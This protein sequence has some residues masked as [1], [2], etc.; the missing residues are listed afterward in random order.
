MIK[1]KFRFS[2]FFSRSLTGL[3]I[4]IF[5]ATLSLTP[6]QKTQAHTADCIP[7]I[8][9][10]PHNNDYPPKV[11]NPSTGDFLITS[12]NPT[13][14]GIDGD[15]HQYYERDYK[16]FDWEWDTAGT[17]GSPTGIWKTFNPLYELVFPKLTSNGYPGSLFVPSVGGNIIQDIVNPTLSVID[18]NT[19]VDY[20]EKHYLKYHLKFTCTNHPKFEVLYNG[21]DGDELIGSSVEAKYEVNHTH[22]TPLFGPSAAGAPFR[23]S[24]TVR[25]SNGRDFTFQSNNYCIDRDKK[26]NY[27]GWKFNGMV[28]PNGN[29][30]SDGQIFSPSGTVVSNFN[31]EGTYSPYTLFG[32][33]CGYGGGGNTI[34]GVEAP[35]SSTPDPT[36]PGP[37]FTNPGTGGPGYPPPP[38]CFNGA[39]NYPL[40]S[41]SNDICLDGATNPPDCTKNATIDG[42]GGASQGTLSCSA[43]GQNGINLV[44]TANRTGATLLRGAFSSTDPNVSV[45]GANQSL[46]TWINSAVP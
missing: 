27:I 12:L 28:L 21:N 32:S 9:Q 20:S 35:P 3:L 11:Y 41:T 6:V 30:I 31:M 18:D 15:P 34:P 22:V 26:A 40:C 8:D 44:L 38:A 37:T 17:L 46:N 5:L 23:D 7:V 13:D 36:F 2:D 24:I 29:S 43:L 1:S 10:L 33:A 42:D 45:T 16:A 4:I 39:T 19:S 25:Y 14:N